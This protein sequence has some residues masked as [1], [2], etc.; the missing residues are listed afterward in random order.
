MFSSFKSFL[1]K[2]P[3]AFSKNHRYDI[4]T[5]KIIQQHCYVHSNCIDVGAHNGQ[6][7]DWFLKFCPQG[8]HYSFEPIP[9]LFEELK[10]KYR[11]IKNCKVFELA[12]S[13][14]KG[15]SSFNYVISNP[16]YSGLKKRVYDR[17]NEKDTTIEVH[18]DTLDNCV[19]PGIKID[20]IKIDVE[21]AEMKVL[22]GAK[23]ILTNDHPILVFEF[24]IGGSDIYGTTPQMLHSFFNELNYEIFLLENFIDKKNSLALDDLEEQF[25]SKR[26]YY[27]V[28][29]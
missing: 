14:E 8:M 18:T 22:Q 5:R 27:F 20:F 7:T 16:A 12:L 21:G 11:N 1:K 10:K 2:S 9:F 19:P 15:I 24:G 25:T 6:V 4:L 13:D 17:K 26:N 3:V 23:K 29:E 28:A